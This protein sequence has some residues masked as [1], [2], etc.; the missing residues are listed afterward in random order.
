[1]EDDVKQANM[2][3]DRRKLA[4]IAVRPN[5]AAA[6]RPIGAAVLNLSGVRVV[7]GFAI[8]I[9]AAGPLLWAFVRYWLFAP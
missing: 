5:A 3:N 8:A 7:T 2:S 1:L 9:A 6:E 4:R